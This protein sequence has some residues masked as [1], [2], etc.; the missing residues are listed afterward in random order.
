MSFSLQTL[1]KIERKK[2]KRSR[3]RKPNFR[4]KISKK[5]KR[6]RNLKIQNNCQFS[7]RH[8][9]KHRRPRNQRILL[10]KLG[11]SKKFRGNRLHMFFDK[12]L[13]MRRKSSW[14]R[15]NHCGEGDF[16]NKKLGKIL[17]PNFPLEHIFLGLVRDVDHKPQPNHLQQG[18]AHQRLGRGE[19]FHRRRAQHFA[20]FDDS[21][22]GSHRRTNF[23]RKNHRSRDDFVRKRLC[24]FVLVFFDRLPK[25]RRHHWKG[26]VA[27]FAAQKSQ[28]N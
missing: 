12:H 2:S 23:L 10:Q 3:N 4:Y 16:E 13:P 11:K 7:F 26:R 18:S 21:F 1:H 24:H 22:F 17:H 15:K 5:P 14:L 8:L 9:Q 25:Q 27:N 20:R 6:H 28:K 19:V